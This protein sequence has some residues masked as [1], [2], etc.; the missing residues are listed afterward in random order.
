MRMRKKPNLPQRI[1]K[2]GPLY[3]PDPEAYRGKW[4]EK[5]PGYQQLQLEIGCGRGRFTVETALSQPD[6]LL[7]AIE[8]VP[9]AMIIGLESA[10]REEVQNVRFINADAANLDKL[11]APGELD[12][13]YINFCDPWPGNRHAKRR[14]T[15][16]NFLRSYRDI[17]RPG[18]E[19]R[20]KT[21]NDDLF[22]FS[23]ESFDLG[24]FEL[25]EVT[26]HLHENGP[27]GIMTDYER[28]FHDQ[29]VS[30]NR[31]VAKLKA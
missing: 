14:L 28:K 11:F 24:G 2:C 10:S 25:A 1:E 19:I 31:C 5:V 23:L 4:L 22:V 16:Q 15:H 3:V 8:R 30:I 9:E 29:G 13:I 6:T 18:G 12:A 27:V 26:R 17:L 20:F 7:V 21:D